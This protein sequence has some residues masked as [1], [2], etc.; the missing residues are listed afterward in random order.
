MTA[1]TVYVTG[2]GVVSCLGST[3]P[4][5]WDALCAGESGIGPITRFDLEGHAAD[6]GLDPSAAIGIPGLSEAGLPV[7]VPKGFA[8]LGSAMPLPLA[9]RTTSYQFDE[10]VLKAG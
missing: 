4:R 8:Q 5:F 9:V 2:M 3:V 7:V 6:R 1:R 10:Y